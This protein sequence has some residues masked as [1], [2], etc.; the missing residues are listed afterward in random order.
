MVC[1]EGNGDSAV[2]INGRVSTVPLPM[3]D[4]RKREI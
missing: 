3:R 4:S 1:Y 2:Y